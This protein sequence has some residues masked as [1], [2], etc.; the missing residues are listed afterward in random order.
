MN[1]TT[2]APVLLDAPAEYGRP[3]RRSFTNGTFTLTYSGE[4]PNWYSRKSPRKTRIYVSGAKEVDFTPAYD[5]VKRD[6]T[7]NRNHASD[8]QNKMFDRLNRE[9]VKNERAVA[10]QAIAEVEELHNM[11]ADLKL[12]YSRYA[13][14][15]CGC[16]PG[17]VAS[18]VLKGRAVDNIGNERTVNITDIWITRN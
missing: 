13:G 3:Y 1:A 10:E 8:E 7:A 9:V 18:D 14:C 12:S 5:L 2:P 4:V 17:F 15:T 16:S 11:L 6:G